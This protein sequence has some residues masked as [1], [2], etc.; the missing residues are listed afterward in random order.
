MKV[1]SEVMNNKIE[2]ILK[3]NRM[4]NQEEKEVEGR[5]IRELWATRRHCQYLVS[6]IIVKE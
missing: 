3:R 1:K 6:R 4:Q 5:E 2:K